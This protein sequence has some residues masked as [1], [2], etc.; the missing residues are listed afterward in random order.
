MPQDREVRREPVA[1]EQ[2]EK[3]PGGQGWADRKQG[4]GQH[5]RSRRL[6]METRRRPLLY[7]LTELGQDLR[8]PARPAGQPAHT[9]SRVHTGLPPLHHVTFVRDNASVD[10]YLES[11][12]KLAR[13]ENCPQQKTGRR[14]RKDSPRS[15]WNITEGEDSGG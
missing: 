9:V 2:E 7:A 15:R 1:S 13:E 3:D 12:Y 4:F 14:S 6:G 5:C 11:F 10:R 8:R